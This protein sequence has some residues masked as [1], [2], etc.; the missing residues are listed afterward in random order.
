MG[1]KSYTTVE[2]LECVEYSEIH[3]NRAT[4]GEKDVSEKLIRDWRKN[5]IILNSNPREKRA[6]RAG[7][8]YWLILEEKLKDYVLQQ[9]S[10]SIKVSTIGII[11][12]ARQMGKEMALTNFLG[13]AAWYHRFKKRNRL[14]IR[15]CTSVGQS[16]TLDWKEKM[17]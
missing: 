2:K 16:F 5:K 9:R 4:E 8:A 17:A 1:K 6:R 7:Q 12:K 14:S 11:I 15:F 3:G 13:T 10:L